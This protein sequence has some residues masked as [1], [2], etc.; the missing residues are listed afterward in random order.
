MRCSIILGRLKQ[1][2]EFKGSTCASQETD[3]TKGTSTHTSKSLDVV[4]KF[5]PG[6]TMGARRGVVDSLLL[7]KETDSVSFGI[8]YLY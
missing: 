7:E 8:Y 6:K 1:G 4:E 5:Y 3:A 2:A